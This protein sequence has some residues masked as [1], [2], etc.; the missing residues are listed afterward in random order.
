MSSVSVIFIKDDSVYFVK[1][2]YRKL[3][4]ILA[5]G[6]ESILP[7]LNSSF[8]DAGY[9]VVDSNRKTIINGQR[10]VALR[11]EKGWDVFEV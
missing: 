8:L 11:R 1:V 6:V 9:I 5:Q 3:S 10:A 4:A 2:H 7:A